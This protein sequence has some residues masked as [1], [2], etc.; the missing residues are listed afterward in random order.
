MLE[1]PPSAHPKSNP[2]TFESTR[3]FNTRCCCILSIYLLITGFFQDFLGIPCPHRGQKAETSGIV[4][5]QSPASAK[6][7]KASSSSAPNGRIAIFTDVT[8]ASA[9]LS[10]LLRIYDPYFITPFALLRRCVP[11]VN[12]L[13]CPQPCHWLS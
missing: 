6:P 8:E 7:T 13:E 1:K 12:T 2:T 11:S 10:K 4:T 3:A 5:S 9:L